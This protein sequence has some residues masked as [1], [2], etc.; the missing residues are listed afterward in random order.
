[1]REGKMESKRDLIEKIIREQ[2]LVC[3]YTVNAYNKSL[4]I[5][6]EYSE[7][8]GIMYSDLGKFILDNPWC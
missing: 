6:E 3:I 7:E 2:D 4:N 5:L 8:N 1:M